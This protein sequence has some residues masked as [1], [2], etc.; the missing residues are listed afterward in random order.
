MLDLS[1]FHRDDQFNPNIFY[2]ITRSPIDFISDEVNWVKV[3]VLMD[4]V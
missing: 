2:I 4:D 3:Y 1:R